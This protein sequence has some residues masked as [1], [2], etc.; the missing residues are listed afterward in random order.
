MSPGVMGRLLAPAAIA[1]GLLVAACGQAG[2]APPAPTV[3]L[4]LDFIPNAVHAPIYEAVDRGRDRARGIRLQIR[5]PSAGPDAVK[6]V[7][8]GRVDLGILDIHDLA[9]A[10]GQGADL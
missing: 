1:L 7:A 10:R 8:S 6:L 3:V 5:K 9:I 2:E 4:S